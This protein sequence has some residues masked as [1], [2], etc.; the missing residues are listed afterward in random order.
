MKTKL[1]Y[2]RI[3]Y[4]TARFQSFST[5]AQHLYISQSAISQ[6]IHQLESDLNVQLFVRTRRGITLTNEGKILFLKVENAI[7]S[8]DQGEKQLEKLRHLESGELKIAAGDTITT[9]FLLKYLEDYHAT[10]P[11]IR[12]EMANSYSSQMLN[13]VKE[14]KADLAFVNMPLSDDELIIEPCLEIDD[15][16][17]CGPDFETKES[18]SWEEVAELP[19]ILLEKHSS[20]RRFLDKNFKEKNIALIPQIEVAVH[21]LLIRFAS[22][23]LGVSCVIEQFAKVELEKGIVQRLSVNPPLPKRSI[24]CAYLK[25]APLSYAA[26]AF[27]EM[28][29]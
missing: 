3:F 20:S 7:N 2:Y 23:H 8:I 1:D 5:A 16:F 19:L 13:L 10:Y 14:G 11:E 4:E 9:H 27:V 6:C 28:I 26:K 15:V 18:Y 21:D 22:I 24:G 12:I 25:N 17:V 29:K